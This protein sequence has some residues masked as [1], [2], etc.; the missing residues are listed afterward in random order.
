MLKRI[1]L[2][3]CLFSFILAA[4]FS[5]CSRVT[6]NFIDFSYNDISDPNGRRAIMDLA[7]NYLTSFSC[8][9]A[10]DVLRPLYYSP[11]VDNDVRMSFASAYACKGGLNFAKLLVSVKN[12]GSDIWSALVSSNWYENVDGGGY[13]AEMFEQASHVLRRTARVPGE[14]E[15]SLRDA[16]ANVFMIFIHLSVIGAIIG[17]LGQAEK[18][19]GKKTISAW[20]LGAQTT[21]MH[22]CWLATS[23]AEI[24]D[25]ALYVTVNAAITKVR[26]SITTA[27][28][29][30]CPTNKRRDR[31][32][33]VDFIA[34]QLI[35]DAINATWTLY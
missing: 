14:W 33:A 21:N 24:V 34:G 12:A 18:V 26:S 17:P 3:W 4:L 9:S 7:D 15:A 2:L 10:L 35:M 5:S 11:W 16:D 1:F 29:G 13:A 23:V 22:R 30:T 19:T 27:C 20:T 25:S 31:C 6:D 28:G 32:G 8:D